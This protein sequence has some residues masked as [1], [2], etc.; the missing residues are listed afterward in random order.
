MRPSLLGFFTTNPPRLRI[1]DAED[2]PRHATWLELFYDLVFVVAVSQLAH[3]LSG[4]VSLRGFLGYAGLFV[5]LWWT[6]IGTTFF[7][8]RFDSDDTIRRVMMGLQMLAIAAL[9]VNVHHAW[10]TTSQGFAI[11]YIISRMLLIVE[12]ARVLKYIPSVR[13]LVYPMNTGF[14]IG[15]LF[16]IVS[17]V[18]PAPWRFVLWGIGLG[19]DFISPLVA[20]EGQRQWPPHAEHLPERFGLFTIIVLGEAVIAVVN[21]LSEVDWTVGVTAA[22]VLG[23]VTAFGLWWLYL[24]IL[25]VR[26]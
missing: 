26:R 2:E 13:S 23:F 12:Y 18:V 24:K 20:A 22:A 8:N 19:V 25:W 21:G 16:W 10:T 9:A 17:L 11:S 7:A 5:P 1:G 15:V 3:K 6:W 14:G 4:D